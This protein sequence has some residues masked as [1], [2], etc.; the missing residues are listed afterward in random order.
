M[1]RH[2][3]G[4]NRA[5]DVPRR[6]LA[7]FTTATPRSRTIAIARTRLVR[8]S[9]PR[10]YR[11]TSPSAPTSLA[12]ARETVG[13][14]AAAVTRSPT[15]VMLSS[16]R[17][18][19]QRRHARRT[20]RH[21][22]DPCHGLLWKSPTCASTCPGPVYSLRTPTDAPSCSSATAS[23]ARGAERRTH[24][25]C[26]SHFLAA[27]APSAGR[28]PR[29][30]AVRSGQGGIHV[31]RAGAMIGITRTRAARTHSA[32][33]DARGARVDAQL[34]ASRAAFAAR[35]GARAWPAAARPWLS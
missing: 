8:R 29:S 26:G 19:R 27:A 35:E 3:S 21:T 4:C 12:H 7:L 34:H 28:I 31:R 24:P 20:R 2:V 22:V 9:T 6:E 18:L 10:Y 1:P 13:E 11:A 5:I 25:P 14:I 23:R 33:S 15:P 32:H 30:W 16:R 17:S